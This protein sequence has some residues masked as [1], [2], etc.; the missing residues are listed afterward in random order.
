MLFTI[1]A[2]IFFGFVFLA[3]LLIYTGRLQKFFNSFLYTIE[4]KTFVATVEEYDEI[5]D[6]LKENKIPYEADFPQTFRFRKE[7]HAIL[8]KFRFCL[9]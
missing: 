6:W 5:F 4:V 1:I 7:D 9:D 2:S 8:F 3:A